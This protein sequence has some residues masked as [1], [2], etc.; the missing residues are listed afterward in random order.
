MNFK[1]KLK[2]EPPIEREF[3]GWEKPFHALVRSTNW[4]PSNRSAYSAAEP[5]E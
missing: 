4:V 3:V 1:L 2:L 5:E